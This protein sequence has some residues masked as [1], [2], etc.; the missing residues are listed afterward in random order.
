VRTG[1]GG[2]HFY[3][4]KADDVE[5]VDKLATYPGIEFKSKGRQV[6]TAGSVH[7][8]TGRVYALDDDALAMSLSEAPDATTALL[9]A[10]RK[11]T[12]EASSEEPGA[13][14]PETLAEWLESVDPTEFKDQKKWQDMM[15]ACHHA[16]NG[17]GADEF[18]AWSTSD[19]EYSDYSEVIR[20]R[21]DS[22]DAIPNGITIRT[23]I[24]FLPQEKRREAVEAIDRAEP[25]DDFPDDLDAE[26]DKARSVW[27]DWVFVAD[28][29]QF[30]RREDGKKYRTDQW[31]ALYAGLNPDGEV[32]NAIWKGRVPMR[33]FE[34]LVYLP[35]KAE[36]SRTARTAAA[37]TSGVRT[38]SRRS[39]ET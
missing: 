38:A 1:G 4:R 2:F 18:I 35:E 37:T 12:I 32:L 26:P 27:D 15:M 6:V 21:W 34:S 7:P 13:I 8:N 10:I 29:M 31:K 5:V 9:D 19:P 14:D 30:V 17:T 28:A 16:T 33:K 11:P 36:C 23:L 24:G 20:Q 3:L 39:R 25:E 22:L